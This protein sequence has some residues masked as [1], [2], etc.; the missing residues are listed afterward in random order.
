MIERSHAWMNGFG[1]LRHCTEKSSQVVGLQLY[2]SATIVTLR[3]VI[4]RTAPLY[5]CDGGLTTKRLK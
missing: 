2:L 3:M 5:R 4:R 1:K